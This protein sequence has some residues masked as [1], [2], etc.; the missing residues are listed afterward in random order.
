MLTEKAIE[1]FMTSRGGLRPMTQKEYRKHLAQFQ[2]AFPRLPKTPP[3][4][5][6]VAE[7]LFRARPRNYPLALPYHQDL[8]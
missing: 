6:V 3:A 4:H 2:K 7:Q 8:L 1:D 5:S